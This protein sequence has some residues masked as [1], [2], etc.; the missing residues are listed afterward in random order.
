MRRY[1]P[2]FMFFDAVAFDANI[3]TWATTEG[4]TSNGMFSGA[5]AWLVKYE[6]DSDGA[7][8]HLSDDTVDNGP[9]SAWSEKQ[10]TK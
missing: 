9:P 6:R 7:E 8:D 4:L 5:T 2:G 1:S 3:T 10:N